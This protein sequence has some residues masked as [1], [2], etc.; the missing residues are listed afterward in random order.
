ML[1]LI[2]SSHL[3]KPTKPK[4]I[5]VRICRKSK[6]ANLYL[7]RASLS[8]FEVEGAFCLLL[9]R[10]GSCAQLKSIVSPKRDL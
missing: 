2:K 1:R 6:D 9:N 5:S 4:V 10:E 8:D 3:R 7:S